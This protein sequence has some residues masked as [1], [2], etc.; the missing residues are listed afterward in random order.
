MPGNGE[1]PVKTAIIGLG[2]AGWDIHVR[3]LRGR[4]GFSVV[5]LVDV[6]EERLAACV[7]ELGCEAY[8]DLASC[9]A[10]SP[11]ELVV[12]ANRSIDHCD[13]A[14]AALEAGRHV[15]VEKPMAVNVAEADCMIAAAHAAGRVLTVHQNRRLDSDLLYVQRVMQSGILGRV[16][17]IKIGV[18][19]YAR[20]NDW[21]TLKAYGGGQLNNWGSHMLDE[22]L[23][24]LEAP[25]EEVFGDLQRVACAGDAEDHVKIVL[26]G[27]N[28]RLVDIEVTGA[29]ALPLPRWVVMGSTG[30]MVIENGQSRI[31]YYDPNQA[32]SLAV[33]RESPPDRRYGNDDVLPWQERVERAA[34][35]SEM[36]FYDHL[37]A[38]LRR[39]KPLLVTPESVREMIRIM[40]LCRQGTEFA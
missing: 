34:A 21:Q 35:S 33:V 30:T 3:A 12:V 11:A 18:Y 23:L 14:I 5:A 20:R 15:L 4:P 39:G 13:T 22:A 2:R 24:L 8:T 7:A 31:R 16:F 9:L 19:N 40:E 32:E 1:Q 26:T 25:V 10:G 37:Y 36:D 29:C 17:E 28:G 6:D 27:Q 38:A